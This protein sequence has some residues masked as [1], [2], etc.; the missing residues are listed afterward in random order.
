MAARLRPQGSL[1]NRPEAWSHSRPVTLWSA[2]HAALQR[3]RPSSEEA[4]LASWVMSRA[5]PFPR[6]TSQQ[7]VNVI[8]VSEATT[9]SRAGLP[10]PQRAWEHL[11]EMG[12]VGQATTNTRL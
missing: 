9:D 12:P 7:P 8:P 2:L 6:H 10:A 3:P 11:A 4:Q 1:Y 5:V